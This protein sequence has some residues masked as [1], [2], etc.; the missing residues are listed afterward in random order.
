MKS[1]VRKR[2]ARFGAACVGFSHVRRPTHD[3]REEVPELLINNKP[4]KAAIRPLAGFGT[5]AF[6][7]EGVKVG[8][9]AGDVVAARALPRHRWTTA[10]A[11]SA[12]V[13]GG[14]QLGSRI[15]FE[16]PTQAPVTQGVLGPH[17]AREP[18]PV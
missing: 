11:A 17:P 12:F 13:G 15:P 18:E 9:H 8:S 14:Y 4:V 7:C 16:H 5:G 1:Q 3:A 2:V 6:L 10:K